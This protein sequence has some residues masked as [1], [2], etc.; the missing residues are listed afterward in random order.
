VSPS[1]RICCAGEVMIEFATTGT[2]KQ[3]RQG[4]AGDSYNT[5]IS[6]S[7]IEK[8]VGLI[9]ELKT[10]NCS[11]IFDPNFRPALWDSLQQARDHY[12]R[13][14]PLCDIVLSGLDDERQ[15]WGVE[16]IEQCREI[17]L[18]YA[19]RERVING[20]DLTAHAWSANHYTQK[21]ARQVPAIDTTGAGDSFNA[22][23]LA[24]RL[25]GLNIDTAIDRA[26][27]LAAR[28]VQHRGAVVLT[29]H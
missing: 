17:S 2:R 9:K 5:A 27:Q 23:Y 21:Q 7:G 14:L 18:P 15:L 16:T 10:E 4:F 1:R 22:G 24:A 26:Q 25:Q 6:R 20:S 12:Q 8:P 11:I 13:V 28:A 3:Y 29:V 19:P